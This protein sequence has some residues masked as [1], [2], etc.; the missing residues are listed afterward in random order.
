MLEGARRGARKGA[1][2]GRARGAR[3]HLLYKAGGGA[4]GGAPTIAL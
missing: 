3:R 4:Q 2:G 1:R